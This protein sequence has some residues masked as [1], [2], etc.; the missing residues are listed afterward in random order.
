MKHL[1]SIAILASCGRV[2]AVPERWSEIERLA[3]PMVPIGSSAPF[4]PVVAGV[5]TIDDVPVA[6]LDG[7]NAWSDAG[8]GLPWRAERTLGK[9]V[10]TTS[11]AVAIRAGRV[12]SAAVDRRGDPAAVRA[13]L[14]LG[15]RLREEGGSLIELSIGVAIAD[16][17]RAVHASASP[18]S[19]EIRLA[20]SDAEVRRGLAAE[21]VKMAATLTER[22]GDARPTYAAYPAFLLD[23]PSDRRVFLARFDAALPQLQLAALDERRLGTMVHDMFDQVAAYRL[24]VGGHSP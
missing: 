9:D 16:H 24:W 12:A 17:V 23:A 8:G 21:A 11:V 15:Q 22:G 14:Y 5:N 6:A 4:D 3:A 19:D 2:S 7:L 18:G 1:L 20:P 10:M 13:A